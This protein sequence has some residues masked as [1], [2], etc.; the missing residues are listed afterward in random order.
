MG[1]RDVVHLMCSEC[2]RK[3]YSTTRNKKKRPEKYEL[4]KYCPFCKKHTL[5]KEVK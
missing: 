3:N 4:K 2:K 1:E 5:H